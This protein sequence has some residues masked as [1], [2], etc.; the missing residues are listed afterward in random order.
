MLA[1]RNRTPN[2]LLCPHR[3]KLRE[4]A[5]AFNRWLIDTLAGVQLVRA[6]VDG[7]VSFLGPGFPRGED[8]VGL[9]DVVFDEGVLGPAVEGE[10]S[11][12]FGVVGARVGYG[13]S[14]ALVVRGLRKDKEWVVYREPPG[15]KP[16]PAT[17]PPPGWPDHLHVYFPPPCWLHWKEPPPSD[18]KE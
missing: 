1:R 15:L 4:R 17:K 3:P 5:R 7:E 14:D 16:V 18:Q 11:G 9:D 13:S 6:L 10:V 2:A 12:A 8:V